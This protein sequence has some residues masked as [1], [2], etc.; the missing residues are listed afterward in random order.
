MA[1]AATAPA[2]IVKTGVIQTFT[3]T[4]VT[5]LD[6]DPDTIHIEDIAHAL[7]N[8]CRYSGHTRKF[9]SVAQHCVLAVRAGRE[10]LKLGSDIEML[11]TI[12]MHDAAEAYLQDVARPLKE[13]EYFGKAY[14]GAEGRAEK[15]LAEVFGFIYPFPDEVKIAD[16]M[17]LGVEKRDLMPPGPEWGILEGIEIPTFE[18]IPW[19]PEKSEVEFTKLYENLQGR[20]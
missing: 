6:L 14:R 10:M 17:M 15:V 18:V 19:G 4:Y 9:Y 16:L 1:K 8:Q 20:R 11:F 5:P 7:A 12:L 3:G 2:R 13:E